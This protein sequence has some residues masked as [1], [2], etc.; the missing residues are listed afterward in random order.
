M[1]GRGDIVAANLTVTPEREKL[2]AFTDP[3]YANAKELLVSGPSSPKVE[4]L[5]QLSGKT[6]LVRKSSSYYESLLARQ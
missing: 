5:E 6:V 2:V 4:S 1:K 3:L